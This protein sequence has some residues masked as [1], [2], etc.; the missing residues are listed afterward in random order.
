MNTV[1]ILGHR[2]EIEKRITPVITI[3]DTNG[4]RDRVSTLIGTTLTPGIGSGFV[5][6]TA[7]TK[8]ILRLRGT[9]IQTG[10]QHAYHW[11]ASADL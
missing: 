2:Y 3:Y 11:E 8:G 7:G 6:N 10:I 5:H 4:A 9:G 1:D